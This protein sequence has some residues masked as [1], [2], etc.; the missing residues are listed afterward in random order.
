[1]RVLDNK[2]IP[3]KIFCGAGSNGERHRYVRVAWHWRW[4]HT[5]RWLLTYELMRTTYHI[6]SFSN[7]NGHGWRHIGLGRFG[8]VRMAN[9]T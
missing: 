3:L 1:M 2:H 9:Q 8:L 7:G 6:R 4:S 5:W